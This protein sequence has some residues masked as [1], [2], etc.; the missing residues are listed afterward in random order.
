MPA[1]QPSRIAL[2]LAALALLVG[3][4]I[5]GQPQAPLGELHGV[6][7]IKWVREDR[8]VFVPDESDPLTY[9]RAGRRIVPGAMFT[10]GGS[11]PRLFWSVKGFSPWSYG[12]AYALH[13]WLF[14]QHRCG[15]DA[16]PMTY[17]LAEAND[18][19]ED[20]IRILVA[21]GLAYGNAQVNGLIK[22]AV[23]QHGQ[24]AWDGP[25]EPGP[26]VVAGAMTAER[27]GDIIVGRIEIR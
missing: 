4:D 5:G 15:L 23:D 1:G 21:D 12:P 13:D 27:S 8:F 24:A 16:P 18:V 20:A 10:D 2:G 19:L 26:T 11:I 3:C 9:E 22:G 25:C 14:R 7:L 17:T 6:L